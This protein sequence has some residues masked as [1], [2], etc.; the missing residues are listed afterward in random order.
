[1]FEI[2]QAPRA[3]KLWSQEFSPSSLV[4][5]SFAE[6]V[7]STEPHLCRHCYKSIPKVGIDRMRFLQ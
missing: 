3:S 4:R 1:M 6:N 5:A 2:T 7:S